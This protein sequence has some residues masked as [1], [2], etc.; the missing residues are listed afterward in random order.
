[1]LHGAEDIQLADR[2][3]AERDRLSA[4]QKKERLDGMHKKVSKE[5][6]RCQSCHR[7]GETYIPFAELGYPPTRMRELALNP[8][9]GMVQK[10]EQ[11]YIP[12]F[13]APGDKR[14]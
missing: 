13:L 6:V 4:E 9:V 5:A 11:F 10:Y 14:R 2:Y 8:V 1:L 7:E 12:S 3:L